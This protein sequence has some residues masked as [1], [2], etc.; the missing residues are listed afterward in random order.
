MIPD[1]IKEK[2]DNDEYSFMDKIWSGG[3]GY[4]KFC[5]PDELPHIILAIV[6][7]PFSII[8]NYHLGHYTLAE[9]IWKFFKCFILPI[10]NQCS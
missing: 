4:G 2:I 7:P 6:F 5:I 8:W 1:K 10:S 9:T 3:L